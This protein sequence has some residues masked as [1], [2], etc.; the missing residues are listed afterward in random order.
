MDDPWADCK[1]MTQEDLCSALK[2]LLEHPQPEPWNDPDIPW[3]D[4]EIEEWCRY[5]NRV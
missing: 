2:S 3:T 1:P 5:A 4:A